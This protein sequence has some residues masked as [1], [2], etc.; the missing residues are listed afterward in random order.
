MQDK[1]TGICITDW[2]NI[3]SNGIKKQSYE[4]KRVGCGRYE[5][6]KPTKTTANITE[7]FSPKAL[8]FQTLLYQQVNCIMHNLLL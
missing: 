2:W 5:S 8:K 4:Y 3:L 6:A 7:N 1:P